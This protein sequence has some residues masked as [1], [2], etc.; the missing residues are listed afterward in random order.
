MRQEN[1]GMWY[2]FLPGGL[3]V[4]LMWYVFL[5]A[6]FFDV[7]LTSLGLY[8]LRL[9]GMAG[10]ISSPLIH[11]DL[12]HL[13]SNSF[14][15][16]LLPAIVLISYPR[17]AFRVFVGVYLFSGL[18]VWFFS[19]PAYHVGASG[20]VYGLASFVFFSG[21]F[22]RDRGSVALSLIIIF[23]YGSMLYGLFPTEERISWESHVIGG[24]VGMLF[25]FAFRNV[26]RP[27]E[28]QEVEE[29]EEET[30]IP[31]QMGMEEEQTRGSGPP[32]AEKATQEEA[33]QLPLQAHENQQQTPVPDYFPFP[34]F[35]DVNVP[36]EKA[37]QGPGE[38]QEKGKE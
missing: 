21:V 28:E 1:V 17:V 30:W 11:G 31:Y 8:P 3:F 13:L 2:S 36:E 24:V 6:R 14:P 35:R 4:G 10:I 33:D 23:L 5:L 22:R 37:G 34:A 12:M 19:R 20:L 9:V 29:Q 32:A 25:A 16:I 7:S 18:G 26:D 27:A 15:L 38:E